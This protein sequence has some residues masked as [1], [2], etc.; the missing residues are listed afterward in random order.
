MKKYFWVII[1]AT[2]CFAC[3]KTI[4]IDVP[5]EDSKMVLHGYLNPDSVIK[6]QLSK[7]VFVL[8]D[9][10]ERQDVAGATVTVFEEDKEL[11]QMQL[12]E[13]GWYEL[14]GYQPK[15]GKTYRIEAHKTGLG[16]I[17]ASE[18]V[19][20]AVPIGGITVDTVVVNEHGHSQEVVE[21]SFFIKDQPGENYYIPAAYRYMKIKEVNP[22]NGTEEIREITH[23]FRM[24][25]SEPYVESFCYNNCV[26]VIN[27]SY[28]DGKDIQVKLRGWFGTF[29]SEWVLLEDRLYV[30][31]F[32]ASPS[33]YLYQATLNKNHE[34]D[35]NPF[36]EP[37]PIYT[38]VEGGYGILASLNPSSREL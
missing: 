26:T 9:V 38:N 16:K 28:I 4:D 34:N 17:T 31:A 15:E 22:F 8:K 27:D 35:G 23:F 12:K 30:K 20:P 11:G 5:A 19:L 13:D 25:S 7:S 36:A 37:T 1:A 29:P 3:E 2:A 14:P 6:V 10:Y 33:Y 18:M 24:E 32:H 21:I